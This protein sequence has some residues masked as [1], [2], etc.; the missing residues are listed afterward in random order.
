M[1]VTVTLNPSVDRTVE[2]AAPL[3]RGQVQR[4]ERTRQDPGGKG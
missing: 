2:L 1:I 3:Q 4:A